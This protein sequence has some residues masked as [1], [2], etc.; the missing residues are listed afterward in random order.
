[1]QRNFH[2][3]LLTTL[4]T[5]N[6]A[7][8][9]A[10]PLTG[11]RGSGKMNMGRIYGKVID[12]D[13]K[14]IGYATV[15]LLGKSFDKVTKTSK[16]TIWAGQLTEGNGDFNIEKLPVVGEYTLVISYLGYAELR[17]QVDF[18]MPRPNMGKRK[19]PSGDSTAQKKN[20]QA[21][22][23]GRRPGGGFSG[24]DMSKFEK[25]LGNIR[26]TTEAEMLN[27]V[28]VTAEASIATLAIDRK[29]YRVDKDMSAVGGTAEDALKNV[30]SLSVD[31]DGN[32]SLRNGSPQIFVDGKQTTL[33]LDQISADAIESVEV[34]TNPSAKYDAGG[35][36]AGIVNIILKKERKIGYNGNFRTGVDSREGYNF[37]GNLNARD[38]KV[39]LFGSLML[40]RRSGQTDGETI[41][42][43]FFDTPPTE[44]TQD[45][46]SDIKGVFGMGRAGVDYFMDNRNTL[47]LSGSYVLGAFRPADI[48][49][50]TTDY[51][52]ST[53]ATSSSYVRT[54]DLE[55][56][57]HNIGFSAQF[58]HLFPRKGAEWTADANYNQVRF[59]R[60]SDFF[61][62][63]DDGTETKERQ[64]TFGKGS[65]LTLQTDFI[66]PTDNNIKLE[67]GLKATL[68]DNINENMNFVQYDNTSDWERIYQLSDNYEYDDDVYAAYIQ[69]GKE[70]GNWG[71]QA[72]LRAESSFY[73][74]VLPEQDSSF[75]IEYPISLFPS[76]F[77][78]RKIN[79]KDQIQLAYSRRITR[80]RFFQTMP[81]TDFSD[82]LNLRRGNPQLIPQFTNSVELSYQNIFENG[83]N[84][85]ISVYY[86]QATNLIA[87][88]QFTEYN[89]ELDREA[90]ITSYANS[91]KAAAYGA[92]ITFKNSIGKWMEITSNLNVYQSD[93]D[94]TNV[95]NELEVS[96]M[97]A[98]LKETVQIKL[99]K[100]FM[101][102][103]NG[104]YRTRASFTPTNDNQRFRGG[105]RSQNTAQGYTKEYWFVDASIRK[106]FL[107][108]KASLTLSVQDIFAT[109]K[110]GSYTETDFFTQETSR[111][112]NPQLVRLS[113]S[114]R[115]GKMD[116]SL[117]NRRNNRNNSQGNDMMGG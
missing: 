99:P 45:T 91:D 8:A 65:F 66:Y 79:D 48:I 5:F 19:R 90:V 81:F 93:V 59:E 96:R 22:A 78:T 21:T 94:A 113:F 17:Q 12:E 106:S 7:Q 86:K 82:S 31:L 36:T 58:K 51:L 107:K 92:E 75:N 54:S 63:F 28:T 77:L 33:S 115:F 46:D 101:L 56:G 88:Y 70:F 95:E 68:R 110:N 71:V 57:F 1:M 80:P 109:R 60:D 74:G 38:E 103:L 15:Q 41:R 72:G 40:F 67:G 11:M 42:N 47:T 108:R 49:S 35:G 23:P 61:T 100:D 76:V 6:L 18:G 84:L 98:F 69:A 34:I 2:I 26:L 97:S 30:P 27:E 44:L 83:S 37:S 112:R 52:Y 4:L 111:I 39:N 104:E 13:G 117:F 87:S 32:V 10:Q 116:A 14:G 105:P 85:L 24:M 50:S 62:E 114:Y 64:E 29:T 20:T 55:R 16:D 43:N 9:I 53:G 3:Y 25:D 89:A 73:T 102:Q